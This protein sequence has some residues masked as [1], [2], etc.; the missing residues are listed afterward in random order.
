[1]DA[2]AGAEGS[3]ERQQE[4]ATD[5][6]NRATK[7]G[8]MRMKLWLLKRIDGAN[9]GEFEGFVIRANSEMEARQ[10]ANTCGEH[11]SFQAAE[12]WLNPAYT[13]CDE[14]TTDGEAEIVL[15]AFKHA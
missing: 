10:L 2:L 1:M 9:F 12:T 8:G 13:T 14:L 5:R 11:E 6:A 7:L 3:E 15:D 4:A